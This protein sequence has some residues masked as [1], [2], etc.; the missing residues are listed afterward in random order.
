MKNALDAI[1]KDWAQDGH[2]AVVLNYAASSTLAQQIAADAPADLFFSADM[3][4][5]D[6]LE[7]RGK[8]R[9]DQRRLLLG[10][11]LVL[12]A[13]AQNPI[14][15]RLEKGTDLHRALNGGRLAMA[16]PRAV[17]A[18]KYGKAA[19][20]FLGVWEQ[21]AQAIA[22][23]EHVR[24]VLNFVARGEAP[25]GIVYRTD[26]QAEPRVRIVAVFPETSHPPIL[27]PV[28]VVTHATHPEAAAFLAYLSTPQARARFETEGFVR[29]PAQGTKQ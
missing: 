22:P 29:L 16:D 28:A 18:G 26:V 9:Q 27:Y 11:E 10:N 23:T 1:A 25:L 24:A 7:T 14:S 21:V 3:G 5:M 19:L 13:G 2:A 20:E 6:W 12:I 8:V 15:L 4:W 17:P